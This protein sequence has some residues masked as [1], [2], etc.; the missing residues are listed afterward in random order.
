MENLVKAIIEEYKVEVERIT[1]E[2][3]DKNSSVVDRYLTDLRINQLKSGE[4]TRDKAIEIAIKK[5]EK[6]YGKKLQSEIEKIN[7]IENAKDFESCTI[8]VVWKKSRMWGSNPTASLSKNGNY[9]QGESIGGCGYDKESVAIA[10]VLNQYYPFMKLLYT[11]KNENENIDKN[12]HEIFGYGSGYGLLPYFEGGVGV[13]CL[14]R[15][16]ESV[17]LVL[18]EVASTNTATV[19][20]ITRK[21]DK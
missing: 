3:K 12:N 10:Q 8:T 7:S 5:L 13:S 17:G 14:Y 19:Y 16:C 11:K 15:I 21:G 6:D 4:I 20:E 9:I 1:N 2:I 18:R